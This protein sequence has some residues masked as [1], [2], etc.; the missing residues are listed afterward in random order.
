MTSMTT[1]RAALTRVSQLELENQDMLTEL[2]R[3]YGELDRMRSGLNIIMG[4]PYE[5][6][7]RIARV[8]LRMGHG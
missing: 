3:V 5:P 8:A 2:N 4:M 1:E 7:A 6:A